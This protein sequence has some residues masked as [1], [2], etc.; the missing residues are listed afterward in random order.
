METAKL[1]TAQKVYLIGIG[2]IGISSLARM[3]MHKGKH[4][5]GVNDSE[6]PETLDE[7]RAKGVEITLYDG[8]MQHALPE[9]SD[10]I[11]VFVY[12]VAWEERGPDVIEAARA[13]GKPVLNYF[14]ALGELS[15][16]YKTIAI[17]GTHGKTTTT[18]MLAYVLKET[19]VN[20]TAVVGSLVYFDD[21]ERTNYLPGGDEY[22]IVE[23]CEYKR[24]FQYFKPHI[25]VIT[26][27]EL[28]HVD[29]YQDLSDVQ[30]AFKTV[31]G[32]SH[33]VVCDAENKTVAPV[34][35]GA[36]AKVIDVASYR[37]LVPNLTVLGEHNKKNAAFVLAVADILEIPQEKAQEALER[38]DGTWRRLEY[39]GKTKGGLHVYDDYAHHPTEIRASI[40]AIR[41]KYGDREITAIFEPHMYSRTRALLRDF[42]VAFEGADRVIVAPIYA[43]REPSDEET[44]A[45]TFALEVRKHHKNVSWTSTLTEIPS[46]LSDTKD[47]SVL[48]FMGAGDIYKIADL[49]IKKN[50]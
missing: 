19:G 3:L 30:D 7:L 48:L 29:Y 39:K 31:V 9:L 14:E 34:S 33:M 11:D 32:N 42:S 8:D 18:A 1:E 20:P 17:S 24:H 40:E 47:G 46:L 36:E 10:D 13:T 6:S 5:S 41:G 22:L 4:V 38:F 35:L 15:R 25:F 27:I 37:K 43:A 12:S 2:G 50:R 26:N 16:S 49:V 21:R 23:A 28:D 44:S 45:E